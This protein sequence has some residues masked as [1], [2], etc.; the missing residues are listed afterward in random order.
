MASCEVAYDGLPVESWRL[1]GEEGN[2]FRL[3]LHGLNPE[4]VLLASEACGIG[5]VALDR[6]IAYAKDRIVFDR[7]IGANQAISHPIAHAHAQLRAAWMMA[8]HAGRRYDAGLECGEA[9]NTAKYLAAEASFYAADRAV[10]TLGGMG[11]ASEYHV[12]RYWREARLQTHRAGHPGDDAQLPRPE[13]P[14]PAPQLL[15]VQ[16]T[17]RGD[18][19]DRGTD[20]S[21]RRGAA[22]RRRWPSASQRGGTPA[23]QPGATVTDVTAP[24]GSGMSSE[25][26]LFTIAAGRR[27][28]GAL[29]RP[30][31]AAGVA[32]VPGVPRVRPRA[33]A[34][35]DADRRPRTP[36]CPVPEVLTHETDAEWLGLAVP[37]HAPGRRHRAVGHPAVHDGRLAVRGVGGRP[38]QARA[39]VGARART[40]ARA[41]ARDATTSRSSTARSSPPARSTSTSN[42]QRWYYDWARDGE[43]VPLIE[44]T[45]AALDKTRPA[46]GPTVLNWGDS[47][48]GNMMFHDFAP[49]AVLDWEMAAL[50]PAEVD[51]A[52]MI[53]MNRFFE[54][55]TQR[56]EMPCLEDFLQRDQVAEIYARGV[57]TRAARP[58]V[59]RDVRRAAVRHRVDPHHAADRWRTATPSSPT[60]ST[61]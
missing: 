5:E 28:R 15:T 42:Y 55:L 17:S 16:P 2:G 33:A 24:E 61:T 56:Y 29:R 50:G 51:V 44:R 27:P 13:H 47:R 1:L 7:P 53:F 49:A 60:T 11:Y 35:R 40:A 6:A 52:W 54:D 12:E 19:D 41:H 26:L 10:Q 36:T 59:V 34:A 21:R 3:L 39:R 30:P 18:D 31:R 43:T 25:T 32:A 9:A 8:L 38:A 58:R 46:E 4:R 37:A 23:G 48:I 22:T 45:F 57:R 14:G 20:A